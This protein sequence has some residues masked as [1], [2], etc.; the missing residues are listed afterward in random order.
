[1]QYILDCL[2]V[3]QSAHRFITTVLSSLTLAFLMSRYNNLM[4]GEVHAF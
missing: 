1:M 3:P 4:R 2:W